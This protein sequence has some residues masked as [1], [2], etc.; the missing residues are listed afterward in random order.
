VRRV[1]LVPAVLVMLLAVVPGTSSAQ[2]GLGAPDFKD[3]FTDE[4]VDDDFCGTG[5][6]VQVVETVVANVWER[7]GVFVKA[8][9]VP[10]LPSRTATRRS[11]RRAR[12]RTSK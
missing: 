6:T 3:R 4:F 5:A 10:G 11:M 9:S 7:D 12:D 2:G 8:T 1:F